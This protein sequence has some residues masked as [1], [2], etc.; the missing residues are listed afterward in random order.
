MKA[1]P[2]DTQTMRSA[3]RF[4]ARGQFDEAEALIRHALAQEP[5]LPATHVALAKLRWPGID[6]LEWLGWFHTVLSPGLYVEIGVEKGN[7]LAQVHA[8]T[9]VVGIDPSP[10]A[11]PQA[12]CAGPI[13]LFRQ[14]SAEF[15]ADVPA[16]CHL[17]T[18]GFDLAFIDGDHRFEEVLADFIALE[19]WAAPEAVVL[20]HDTIP[21]TSATSTSQRKTGFYSG[22]AWKIVPCL[23]SLRPDLH[24]VTLPT[25]PTGLTVV[26]GLNSA[27]RILQERLPEIRAAYAALASA[28]VVSTPTAFLALGK[29]DRDWMLKWLN[30]AHAQLRMQNHGQAAPRGKAHPQQL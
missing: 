6:Y 11:Q 5:N 28:H 29:N 16:D 3:R 27:S 30:Q 21:L 26:T 20:M 7:S 8:D 17:Q 19:Q 10:Q 23:R 12:R 24:L 2:L 18:R 1:H 9:Q 25:A 15:F 4:I 13:Q 22:D 14:T